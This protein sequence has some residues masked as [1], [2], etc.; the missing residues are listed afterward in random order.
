[1]FKTKLAAAILCGLT[2]L[3]ILGAPAAASVSVSTNTETVTQVFS[4]AATPEVPVTTEKVAGLTSVTVTPY[5][6]AYGS[7]S[8]ISS[9]FYGS[10]GY[11]P[12]LC[13][14]NGISNCD[15]LDVGQQVSVPSSPPTGSAPSRP[16]T[17][18][19]SRSAPIPAANSSRAQTIVNYALAQVGKPYSWAAAGPYSFDCSGLVMMA[20]RQVGVNVPH[21]DQ[22]ILY[23]GLGYTVSRDNLQAGDI[24][25]PW[26]GHVFVYIGNGKIVEAAGYGL[27]VKVNN[28]YAFM[29]AKRYV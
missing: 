19:A 21:Q 13:Q 16:A 9:A 26:A 22:S 25:W 10:A 29:T 6:S 7:L 11:W 17:N 15:L 12:G 14:A 28:L 3:G 23:S 5:P 20:L 1:M 8:G 4:P 2:I 27:G 18:T 24:V